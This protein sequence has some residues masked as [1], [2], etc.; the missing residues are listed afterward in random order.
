MSKKRIFCLLSPLLMLALTAGII[1]AQGAQ[2]LAASGNVE[3]VSLQAIVGSGFTY[4]GR[5]EDSSGHPVDDVCAFDFTLWDAESGG[6]LVGHQIVSDVSVDDG[7]LAVLLN[8]GGELG[9]RPF[10]GEARWLKISVRCSGDAD[11]E[12]LPGRQLV[13]ATPYALSLRPGAL[14]SGTIDG[15]NALSIVNYG[16]GGNALG[17][18]SHDGDGVHGQS[19]EGAGVSA[20]SFNAVAFYAESRNNTAGFFTSTYG[21]GIGANTTSDDPAVSAVEA[22]NQGAG[23]GVV[24]YSSELAGIYGNSVGLS[25]NEVGVYGQSEY[26]TA[27]FFTSTYGIGVHAN[28]TTDDQDTAAVL[29]M[30]WGAGPGVVGYSSDNTGVYGNSTNAHGVEGFS[31]NEIGVY[32]RSIN[33]AAATFTSTNGPAIL[34]EGAGF[35]GLRIMDGVGGDYIMAGSDADPDFKVSN[36]GDVFADGSYHCEQGPGAE[37][38]TCVIQNSPADLA[39]MLPA[40]QGLEPGDVLI[41]G[42]DGRLARSTQAYQPTV[43]GVYSTQP[44]Y[45]GG[46]EHWGQAGY[47]PLAVVG[48][49]P[50]KVS[51]EN[52]PIQPGDLLVASATPGYAMLAGPNPPLGTVIG[53]A[54]AGLDTD[55]GSIL[56]LAMLQ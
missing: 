56:M 15:R 24:G 27:G 48:I 3:G 16:L 43:V 30:N 50:V 41:I 1:F 25:V 54:L 53:K 21:F 23:P 39:E 31:V 44:G 42:P 51:A 18:Y 17:G 4:Q 9:E 38:G 26:S 12:I 28:T 37:P 52:G 34:V 19:V 45:L 33:A 2:P 46:G 10:D 35:E 22:T 32:G 49:V 7:Y 5:L 29:G 8:G 6:N 14:I 11:W 55:S 47:A 40:S 36:I 20:F 13:S